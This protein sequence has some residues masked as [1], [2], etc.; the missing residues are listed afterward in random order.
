LRIGLDVH[1][2][3]GTPQG[4]TSVW[5][6]LLPA[7]PEEHTYVLYSFDPAATRREFPAARFEHRRIP[8]HQSHLR[9]ALVYPWLARRDRCQVF[10]VNY[11]GPAIGAPGLVVTCH[12]V[13]FLDFP[14]LA[15]LSRRFA[16]RFLGG[17]T[18]AAARQVLTVSEYT[19]S[20]IVSHFAVPPDR[21]T[22]AHNPIDA[23][24][25]AP[26]A[27]AVA[28]AAMRLEQRVPSRFLLGV[29]R[30]EPRKNLVLTARIARALRDEGLTDGLVWVGA[31]D[32]GAEEIERTLAREGLREIVV[33]LHD[34]STVE[35][36]AL[37]RKAQAL[38]F[39][40]LA[41]GFGY[42]VLE[43]M[44]IGTPAVVSNRTAIPE[45]AG[46]GACVVDP[47]DARAA[48][49]AVRAVI[50]TPHLRRRLVA[51]GQLRAQRF[52][53]GETAARVADVYQRAA[54]G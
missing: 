23:A 36:Q 5:R 35:L 1:T 47:R 8:I 38:V 37:Y 44:A 42:P 41:E 18:L 14:E 21:I 49:D 39:L 10:H 53:A 24:W 26:D 11:F 15:P 30:L 7:L 27:E 20:R 29:G 40:S 51:A 4:T 45:V 48:T 52:S 2:L 13:L 9:I 22:V 6:N 3:N 16:T 34:L 31:D 54:R 19:K 25:L 33:R 50:T 12:D 28:A 32:F 17:L 43:A 46:D